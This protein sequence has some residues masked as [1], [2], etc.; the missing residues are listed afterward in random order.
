[1]SK[2]PWRQ[3]GHIERECPRIDEDDF[4]F[5]SDRD[6]K[7]VFVATNVKGYPVSAE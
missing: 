6:D 5:V 2:S 4:F 1:M 7:S 3:S